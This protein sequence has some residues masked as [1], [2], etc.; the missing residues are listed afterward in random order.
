MWT[1]RSYDVSGMVAHFGLAGFDATESITCPT[2]FSEVEAPDLR[3][4]LD[5]SGAAEVV[6]KAP[7][8]YGTVLESCLQTGIGRTCE[9]V[10]NCT[11]L[12]CGTCGCALARK[13]LSDANVRWSQ[14]KTVLTV[15]PLKFDY[16]VKDETMTLRNRDNGLI[17]ELERVVIPE[18]KCTG[19]A[20]ECG[21]NEFE[22]DCKLVRGCSA[23][24]A[25]TGD[26]VRTC[27]YLVDLCA[28][29][30][31]GCD[32]QF[33]IGQSQCA[34]VAHCEDMKTATDCTGLGCDWKGYVGCGGIPDPCESLTV[35][36]CR[37]TPGCNAR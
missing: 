19:N 1:T 22:Q 24:T 29:C 27:D 28:A 14:L 8:L 3:L 12:G 17:F 21:L 34:G 7:D 18:Q 25:C 32:C 2:V 4:V 13:D 15:G 26:A 31:A 16:C 20:A 36:E 35:A 9:Q 5:T 37:F 11:S 23:A 33:N 30:P 10:P 6:Y